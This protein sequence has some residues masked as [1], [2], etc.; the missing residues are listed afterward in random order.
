MALIEGDLS[1]SGV[2]EG[3]HLWVLKKSLRLAGGIQ[4]SM[5]KESDPAHV[6]FD[7]DRRRTAD[8]DGATR[9][10][11]SAVLLL[12]PGR[13]GSRESSAAADRESTS[14]LSLC[15]SD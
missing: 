11:R 8:H 15:A 4:R 1:R 7:S 3:Y 6:L 5:L 10:L 13:S 2:N 9:P 14:V 12:P